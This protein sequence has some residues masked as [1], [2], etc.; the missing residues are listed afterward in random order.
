[1]VGWE[2]QY[3]A[4]TSPD[5][6]KPTADKKSMKRKS[7]PDVFKTFPEVPAFIIFF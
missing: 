6:M 1:M 5:L 3:R 7:S 4:G 2:N